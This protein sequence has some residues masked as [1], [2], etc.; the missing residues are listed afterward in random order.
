M[1]ASYQMLHHAMNFICDVIWHHVRT[2]TMHATSVNYHKSY[3]SLSSSL[4]KGYTVVA[5]VLLTQHGIVVAI[6]VLLYM[7]AVY[8][9]FSLKVTMQCTWTQTEDISRLLVHSTHNCL[10]ILHEFVLWQFIQTSVSLNPGCMSHSHLQSWNRRVR[11]MMTLCLPV[12]LLP[13]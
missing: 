11:I 12:C 13:W 7:V 4:R 9:L 10:L 8:V 3:W 1:M 6:C 5:A 2:K